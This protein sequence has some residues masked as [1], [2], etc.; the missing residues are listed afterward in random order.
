[1]TSRS[2]WLVS[3]TQVVSRDGVVATMYPQATEAGAEMLR[4]GGNAVDA[5]VAA[6]YA[7]G[8]VEPFNSGL[9]GIAVLVHH[10]SRSG[11]TTVVDG[12]GALPA[13]IRPDQFELV[14]EPTAESVY[15][16]PEVADGANDTG[17]LTPAVPGM[18]ACLGEAHERFGVLPRRDVLAP[19]IAFAEH[20][21][22]VDWYVCLGLAVNQARLQRF[23]ESRRV[24]L[25]EDGSVWRAP[26]LGVEGDVFR[27]AD[28]GRTLR[29]IAEHGPDVV[30]RGEIAEAIATDV[31]ANGGLLAYED[32]VGYRARVSEGG[33]V[34]EYRGHQVVGG[35][36][37]TGFPTVL[38]ALLLLEGYDLAAFGA[39]SVE[40]IHVLA[41]VQRLA[42]ADR[43][44]HLGDGDQVPVPLEGLL[45]RAYADERR[46]LID[47]GRATPDA[48]AGDPWAHE[49]AFGRAA[50]RANGGGEGLTT[51]L[52]VVDRDRNMVSL[53]STLGLHFGSAVVP[54]GTGIALNNGTM[55]FDPVPGSRNSIA[56]GR[57]IMTAGAPTIVLRDGAPLLAVGA[58]GGRRVISAVLQSIVNVVDHGMSAQDAVTM[59]RV[60]CEGR[61][62]T[63][64]VRLGAERLDALRTLG[65]ELDVREETFSTTYFG[66]PNM[67]MVDP[68][69]HDLV[70]GVNQYKP[71]YAIGL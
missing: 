54:R 40:E 34:G 26:M 33:I 41:E 31:A 14:G 30:Y 55:W 9:G 63:A 19:A 38:Q 70:G 58:P 45:S 67:V 24:F 20:G 51:H 32:L 2:E 27:Q 35:P 59:P 68:A 21:F 11:R 15:G 23:A 39:G 4:R 44:L 3:K 69:T 1:L 7:I 28:L 5:A 17:W 29:L 48:A 49:S 36:E 47:R 43:F 6:G 8:V 61:L 18:P 71:A 37:N 65:H 56:P 60:H 22:P 16:W 66:R 25:K 52:T 10:E 42:F 62:T 46:E 50:D 12:T 13:A 53:L 64:D 57:R